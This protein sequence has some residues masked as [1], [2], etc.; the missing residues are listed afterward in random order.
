MD[1]NVRNL[2]AALRN[3]EEIKDKLYL[4]AVSTEAYKDRLVGLPHREL[5][6]MSI[7][8]R[9]LLKE[10]ESGLVSAVIT[11]EMLD[12][13][14]ISEEQLFADAC[15]S[16]EGR[17]RIRP[18]SEVLTECD[19]S[20]AGEDACGEMLYVATND[21]AC[22]GSGVIAQPGFLEEAARILGGSFYVLPSS[23]HEV[24]LLKED[25]SILP[26]ELYHV[27]CGI[28]ASVVDPAEKLTD[29][30][31]RYDEEKKTFQQMYRGFLIL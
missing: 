28:N 14:G 2:P 11:R 5:E 17:C 1:L 29:N 6:D 4:Q 18:L 25:G 3:Y 20:F 22:F 16:Q 10:E 26:K 30:V 9:I 15:A 8:F 27:V 13:Y 24:I 7:L 12:D 23:I 31:Y 21:R 19:P